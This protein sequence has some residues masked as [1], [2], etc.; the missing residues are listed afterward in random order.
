[1]AGTWSSS[2]SPAA[3]RERVVV[4]IF[5]NPAQFAPHE[6]LDRYPRTFEADLAGLATVACDLV[7]APTVAEMYPPG[8][9]TRV[10]P[11]GAA[12][13]LE[14]DF[15]PHFFGGVATVCTKLFTQV[16]PDFA[17]FGEK[18]YQQLA[19]MRQIVRDLDLPLEIVGAPTIREADGLAHV[20]PQPLPQRG[21]TQDRPVAASH[22]ARAGNAACAPKAPASTA[23]ESERLAD[24]AARQLDRRRLRQDRLCRGARCGDPGAVGDGCEAGRGRPLRILAAAWLGK[25]R[26]IDNIAV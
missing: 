15:R 14:T 11:A 17:I 21:R 23:T 7:W 3:M 9:A 26:L 1:M 12:D 25:T 20:L 6:D 16:A 10:V 19:V 8:H 5:V 18:D 4:S 24:E 13:G 22:V 2:G